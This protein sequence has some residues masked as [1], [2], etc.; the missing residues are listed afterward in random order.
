M[1]THESRNEW[2]RIFSS[3]F[4]V[5]LICLTNFCNSQLIY[6]K[7][8]YGISE[9]KSIIPLVKLP[10]RV[11]SFQFSE[12]YIHKK[13]E[14]LQNFTFL[15]KIPNCFVWKTNTRNFFPPQFCD[16]CSSANHP[17]E[18]FAKF[19]NIRKFICCEFGVFTIR[20]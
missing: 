18:Y 10:T 16:A 9:L 12:I 13:I 19:S 4:S 17:W 3:C 1:D 7:K 11:F 8:N 2:F 6:S 20:V 15:K 14:I 5:T